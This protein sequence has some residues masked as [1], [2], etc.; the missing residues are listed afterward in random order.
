MHFIGVGGVSMSA[1]AAWSL[2]LGLSVSGSD[3]EASRALSELCKLGAE[4]YTGQRPQVVCGADIVVYSLAIGDGDAELRLAR[5]RGIL[6]VSR[7]EFLGAMML[8]YKTRIGVSGTHGKSTVTAML[9]SI[10][11]VAC[12][13]PTV[14]C[15]APISDSGSY[16]FGGE[17]S[18]I[19]EA[20]EYRMA[21]LSFSPTVALILNVDFDHPDCYGSIEE[22]EDAFLR[23][24][25]GADLS[26]VNIDSAAAERVYRRIGGRRV[27]VGKSDAADYRYEI[28]GNGAHPEFNIYH[29]SRHVATLELRVI[30][31]HNVANAVAAFAVAYECGISQKNIIQA[32]E[33]FPGIGRRGELLGRLGESDVYYD[34][35]HHPSEIRASIKAVRALGY[36]RVT[37]LF[38]PHTYTRTKALWADFV[39]ALSL[40]DRVILTEIFPAREQP[41]PTVTSER[42]AKD[43]G[44]RASFFADSSAADALIPEKYGAIIL[45]GAGN[46]SHILEKIKGNEKFSV[47]KSAAL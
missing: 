17:E 3:R 22:V 44:G 5:G 37:V 33:R 27:S 16:E 23:S 32:L 40:A 47:D 31:E 41:I 13:N 38:K 43:I 8:R 25:K 18:L 11:S 21:F 7:A 34:Y 39:S 42:L 6:T 15:G 14:L 28:V 36:K 19:Y 12:R 45:M 24:T 29:L 20:C 9:G 26:V 30:G 4:A 35:A 46:I 2:R 10:F 1:L